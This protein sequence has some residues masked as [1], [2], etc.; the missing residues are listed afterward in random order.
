MKTRRDVAILASTMLGAFAIPIAVLAALVVT[1]VVPLGQTTVAHS[2]AE[3][4][5]VGFGYPLPW[6]HQDQRMYPGAETYP[7]SA[8]WTSPLEVPTS[9][10]PGRFFA[11]WAIVGSALL[12]ALL[13][14]AGLIRLAGIGTRGSPGISRATAPT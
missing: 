2:R 13:C 9:V 6:M 14:G 5:H 8:E 7:T 1:L 4:G 3:L 10:E 12:A 11:D